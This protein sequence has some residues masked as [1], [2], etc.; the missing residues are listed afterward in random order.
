MVAALILL[1]CAYLWIGAPAITRGTEA[2]PSPTA[3][4][5]MG[6]Q[7]N[8]AKSAPRVTEDIRFEELRLYAIEFGTYETIEAARVEAA[9]YV[10]RGAAGYVYASSGEYRVLGAGYASREEADKVLG[11]LAD[12]E[13]IAARVTEVSAQPVLLRVTAS[14][15][16]IEAL[17]EAEETL[18]EATEQMGAASFAIDKGEVSYA[19]AAYRIEMLSGR[20]AASRENL[21]AQAGAHPN[22]VVTGLS[23]AMEA[24]EYGARDATADPQ[25]AALAFSSKLKYSYL[26]TRIA[27]ISFLNALNG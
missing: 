24:F 1:L 15:A 26:N 3:Q 8:P 17:R 6:A 4:A 9:R 23:G 10:Q 16:Q 5:A 27:H 12:G 19:E 13:G 25:Q 22:A 2:P 20:V 11:Q 7:A 18:R 21:N 14:Q